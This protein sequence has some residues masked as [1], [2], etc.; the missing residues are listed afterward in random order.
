MASSCRYGSLTFD[1]NEVNLVRL[2]KSVRLAPNGKRLRETRLVHAEGEFQ[3]STLA[4]ILSKIQA[5][6]NAFKNDYGDFTYTVNG[7]LAHSLSN[8]DSAS[9]V[10]VINYGY[11]KGDAAEL[12][13]KRTFQFTLQADYDVQEQDLVSFQESIEQQGDGGPISFLMN[14]IAGPMLMYVT[15]RSAIAF[16]QQGTAVGYRDYPSPGAPAGT[17]QQSFRNSITRI[18]GRQVGNGFRFFTTKW[19]YI[20][21]HDPAFGT[22]DPRP[23]LK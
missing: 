13:V 5:F 23:T 16:V 9:G 10:R 17:V 22:F 18:G 1:D 7:S 6:E 11:P 14:T 4:T 15:N 2:Q 3:S 20:L 12:S 8:G 19:R 21:L